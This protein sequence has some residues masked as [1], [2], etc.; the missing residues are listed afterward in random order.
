MSLT[1]MRFL[2]GGIILSL[3][4]FGCEGG[5]GG[6]AGN[7]G[8]SHTPTSPTI[9]SGI[10]DVNGGFIEVTDRSSPIFGAKVEIP[11]NAVG[12]NESIVITLS[13]QDNLPKPLNVPNARQ[14][15]KVINLSKNN[16]KN[17]LKPVTVTFPYFDDE[18]NSG[19]IPAVFYFDSYYDTYVSAGVQK[20]D[21]AAKYITFTTVHFSRFAAIGIA[22]LAASAL[23]RTDT[24]FLPAQDGFFHP[25]FGAYGH[26]GGSCLGMANYAQWYYSFKR[27]DDGEDLYYKYRENVYNVWQD[28]F[29]AI[30]LISRSYYCSKQRWALIHLL[31]DYLMGDTHTGLVLLTTLAVTNM[32]QTLCF[33]GGERDPDTNQVAV[34]W[35]H[36]V[37][38]YKYESGKF[39]VYDNNFPG[40]VVTLDW[41]PVHG[42][43]G[44]SKAAAYISSNG[45]ITK[46]GIEAIG[47]IFEYKEFEDI[48]DGAENGWTGSKFVTISVTSPALDI[49]SAAVISNSDNVEVSGTVS[50]GIIQATHI[51]YSLNGTG[52]WE[53]FDLIDTNTGEFKFIISHLPNP[54]NTIHLMAITDINDFFRNIPHS[55]AGFKE[56]TL[57]IEGLNFFENIGFETGDYTGWSHETHTWQ[58]PTE[59]SFSPEKSEI[60]PPGNDEIIPVIHRV[61]HGDHSVRVNN[62]DSRH[63]ISG[64]SQSRIVPNMNNPTLEFYWAA[65]LEDPKHH[66]EYQPYIE[67]VVVNE[68]SGNTLYYQHFYSND[69][70]YSGWIDYGNWKGIPW[71]KAVVNLESSIGDTVRLNVLAAD[72][73]HG[74]HGGYVY[75]DSLE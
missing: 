62:F 13:Y 72:C 25:N 1:F 2:A 7:S 9:A 8:S 16:S 6:G 32:P 26:P 68:T 66:Y 54:T 15:S 73:G 12:E 55:Y 37:S 44:Y 59:G 67:I 46:W 41:D 3:A 56:I 22:G 19:D 27:N 61:Y 11:K 34:Q 23:F 48:Y 49:N 45:K 28:D 69:P 60:V 35:G 31:S 71:Q 24:G 63:H 53:D 52:G 50:G 4:L 70:A 36:V 64:V 21:A 75:L 17:F 74:G 18:L 65:V 40:E 47:N 14:A 42:F 58:D 57:K 5:G 30:E 39:Y 29:T 33:T 43:S 38:V 20:I 10:V 51:F